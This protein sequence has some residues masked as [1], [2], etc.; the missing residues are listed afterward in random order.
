MG[1]TRTGTIIKVGEVRTFGT[2]SVKEFY[3]R[4]SEGKY[5][6][7]LKIQLPEKLFSMVEPNMVGQII[8]VQFNITGK[9]K[10]DGSLWNNLKAWKIESAG[11]GGQSY[12]PQ[13]N[14]YQG[15]PGPGQPSWTGG[16]Q[17]PNGGMGTQAH[18]PQN[19]V[20]EDDIPF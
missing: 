13:P 3:L 8:T 10:D 15:G 14:Q 19:D 18:M 11:M 16:A 9:M 1:E 6:Q 17:G 20:I 7:D 5:P 2:F 12:T 4:E